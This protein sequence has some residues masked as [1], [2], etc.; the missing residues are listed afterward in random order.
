MLYKYFSG[1][2]LCSVV[3]VCVCGNVLPWHLHPVIVIKQSIV[4]H[5]PVTVMK[6]IYI[7]QYY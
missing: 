7:V 3:C 6:Q 2:L 1:V 5:H 4:E